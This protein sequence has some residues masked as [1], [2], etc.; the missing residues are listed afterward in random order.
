MGFED[1]HKADVAT[2]QRRKT[3]RIGRKAFKRICYGFESDDWGADE[4]PC[5]DCGVV[6]GQLHLIGCDVERCPKCDGQA[7]TCLCSYPPDY[8]KYHWE[9]RGFVPGPRR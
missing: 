3:Y 6:K 4:Y 8:P 5:H 7:L 1:E 9:N 2:A